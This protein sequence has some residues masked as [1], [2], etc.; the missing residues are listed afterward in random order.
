ME[1]KKLDVG[2]FSH[3]PWTMLEIDSLP[4]LRCVCLCMDNA[5]SKN[6]P[7]LVCSNWEKCQVLL[8]NKVV[9]SLG[10][11]KPIT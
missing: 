6:T 3:F 5:Q 11:D 1:E 8:Q 2:C 10:S 7:C 4:H 9:E